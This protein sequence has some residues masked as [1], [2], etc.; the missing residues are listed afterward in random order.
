MTDAAE[1]AAAGQEARAPSLTDRTRASSP[2][3]PA[4]MGG[5]PA[6]GA[7]PTVRRVPVAGIAI[8]LA[9]GVAATVLGWFRLPAITRDTLWAEDS[10]L[11]LQERVV[12]GP[13][14][15]LLHPY[16]GYQHL[17]PRVLTDVAV[18]VAP[19]DRYATTVTLLA[20]AAVGVT[21]AATF[22][23]SGGML[24]TRTARIAVSLVPV[25]LPIVAT[26]ALGNFAN[27]HWFALWLAP[28]LLLHRPATRTRAVLQAVLM[29]FVTMTEIQTVVFL[30]LLLV[31]VRRRRAWPVGI[32]AL[33]G[34]AV[35]FATFLSSPRVRS[36]AP[37]FVLDDAVRGFF[38]EPSLSVWVHEG[39]RAARLLEAHGTGL[40]AVAFAPFVVALAVTVAAR[41]GARSLLAVTL[42]SGAVVIW[43]VDLA[44]NP[45]ELVAF[46]ADGWGVLGTFG[47]VRYALVPSMFLV[48]L[49][50]V[51][52][53]RL[54][55]GPD[56]AGGRSARRRS[57][58]AA[59]VVARVVGGVSLVALAGVLA[60]AY[61]PAYTARSDGPDWHGSV[62]TAERT[63]ASE[64]PTARVLIEGAP[65]RWGVRLA[66]ADVVGDR[67]FP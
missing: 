22:A 26:E 33:V 13:W 37:S 43:F 67:R 28:F 4:H 5:T 35:Q 40:L 56:R 66:C 54:L 29:A 38:A 31:V 23:F 42:A 47:F 7:R 17:V 63:C 10:R 21:A 65:T 48:A 16:D 46:G 36:D 20:L 58:T 49:V 50:V 25:L 39:R 52:A 15:T 55:R 19:I 34:L 1:H 9:V 61:H 41:W 32:V 14:A 60:S 62:R 24:R 18:A 8:A 3:I 27:L 6:G 45:N 59:R 11:F 57:A 30:P 64:P 2:G 51:A 44:V 12:L 53:D